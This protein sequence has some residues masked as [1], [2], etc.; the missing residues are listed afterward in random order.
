METPK[1]HH[2]M[3]T[4]E[5]EG[6]NMLTTPSRRV[7][8]SSKNS[9]YISIKHQSMLS[10]KESEPASSGFKKI[11]INPYKISAPNN[12]EMINICKGLTN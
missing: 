2:R 12:R 9:D 3:K 1:P 10:I 5:H 6:K 4:L 8:V 11:P 7:R